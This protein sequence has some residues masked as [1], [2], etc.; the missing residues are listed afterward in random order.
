MTVAPSLTMDQAVSRRWDAVVVGAGPAGS[1]AALGLARR[2]LDVL[3]V[4][5]TAFPRG[6]IC[7]CC[8]NG[9][10]L[11][12][13]RVAG[14]GDLPA[15]CGAVPLAEMLLAA[16]GRSAALTMGRG[17]VLSREALDATLVQAA[18][19]AGVAFLP[20]T[21]ATLG[22][23]CADARAITLDSDGSTAT[24]RASVVV[25]ADGLGGRLFARDNPDASRV[26]TG[27]RLGAGVAVDNAPEFYRPGTIYMACGAG[28]YVGLV[29]LEDGR[30]DIAAAL[31]PGQI[32][33]RHGP[34][35]TVVRLLAEANWP[36]PDGLENAGWK[37]TLPLTRQAK[38]LAAG[39]VF[40]TGDAAG[41]IEP[42]TG[43]G[44]G[45][46]LTS[47]LAV[48]PIAARA[49]RHWD[50]MLAR[51]WTTTYHRVVRRQ[52]ACRVAA[53]VLRQPWLARSL[54]GLLS[55]AP[56]LAGPVVRS[57]DTPL[58]LTPGSS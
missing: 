45:R 37:G 36:A 43:E 35:P 9:A 3:L 46:A 8:L 27:A 51:E 29:R 20:R 34:G 38:Y 17:V 32:R 26:V 54:I 2:G 13:L 57:L 44:I 49:S 53:F 39:R 55:F 16:R 18:I 22:E 23:L 1:V 21:M 58:F 4:D 40:A 6:K 41:Y 7:G 24:V 33:A 14:V 31:D 48:V 19:A 12:A 47:G 56:A 25:A 5:R 52:L 30:L 50:E 42:F 28:G 15:R 10:A 11:A